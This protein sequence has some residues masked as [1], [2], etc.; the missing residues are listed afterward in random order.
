MFGED[1]KTPPHTSYQKALALAKYSNVF[2]KV[3]GLGE[4]A[5]RAA[6]VKTPFPFEDAPPLIEMAL[7]AF[8]ARRLMWGSDF[9]PVAAREG[10]GNALKLPMENVNFASEDDK[11]WVFGKTAASLWRFGE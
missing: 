4:V 6:P 1:D 9:P 7:D 3:P 5:T 2:M 8:G 11:E 10:Y